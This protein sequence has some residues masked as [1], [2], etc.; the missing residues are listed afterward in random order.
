M[1][2][3]SKSSRAKKS[4][5]S[6]THRKFAV[7]QKEVLEKIVTDDGEIKVSCFFVFFNLTIPK[8]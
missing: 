1:P 7:S 8:L 6:I 3:A 5:T 4:N 2:K